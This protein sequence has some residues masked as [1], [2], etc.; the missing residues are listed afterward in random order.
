MCRLC[1]LLDITFDIRAGHSHGAGLNARPQ[2]S[3]PD[4][5]GG[6]FSSS[7]SLPGDLVLI[8]RI[9]G[10]YIADAPL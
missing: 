7:A 6:A 10:V 9:F 8:Y 2:L 5:T 3:M 1:R 4:G